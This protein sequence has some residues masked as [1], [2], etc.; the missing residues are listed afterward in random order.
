MAARSVRASMRVR[1]GAAI[2][3]G[4]LCLVAVLPLLHGCAASRTRAA[5]PALAVVLV[6]DQMRADY[7]DRFAGRY[8]AGLARLA[9]RGVV[10]TEAHQDHALTLTGPGYA[11]VATGVH[12]AR[13]GIVGNDWWDRVQRRRVYAVEDPDSP[14]LDVDAA[15]GRSPRWLLRD[16]LGDWLKRD[17][18]GGR[19]FSVAIKDRAAILMGGQAPDG[20]FWYD[21]DSGAFVTSS[22]YAARTPEWVARFNRAGWADRYLEEGWNRL[23]APESY[24]A[25]REDAFVAEADGVHTTFPHRFGAGAPGPAYYRALRT[26]PFADELTL[27][28]V[29]ELISAEGP[30]DDGVPDVLFVGLSAADSVGHAFGPYSQEVEDYYLRL[31]GML[32]RLLDFLDRRVGRERYLLALCADHGVLA[33]PEELQR[34]GV[35]AGRVSSSEAWKVF[36]AAG[37]RAAS[38]LGLSA[39]PGFGYVNGLVLG[40]DG[41]RLSDDQRARFRSGVAAALR[42]QTMFDDVF[43]YDELIDEATEDR[44]YLEMYR[45]SFHPQRAPDL[46]SLGREHYLISAGPTS[47]THGSPYRYDTH[48]PLIFFGHGLAGGRHDERVGIVDLAPTLAYLLG[49]TPPDDLDGRVLPPLRR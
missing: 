10:F 11:T 24:A 22:F 9:A 44:P 7:M 35:D 25:S 41:E 45:R 21:D 26:T 28:F 13:S 20:V 15:E 43:T 42:E 31:D 27:R 12:P 29:R 5:P 6:V 14:I 49:L 1:R 4:A 48:V 23:R 2:L 33:M 46:L 3:R 32:G 8:E 38:E 34:R 17:R 40:L 47:T 16:T 18:P 19:V 39:A 37:E 36:S 30:G